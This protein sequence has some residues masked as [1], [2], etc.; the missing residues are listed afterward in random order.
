M[1]SWLQDNIIEIYSIYNKKNQSV[2][3]ERFVKALTNK[4]NKYLTNAII[5][6]IEQSK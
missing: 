6:I 3:T 2:V 1:S 5:N 4:T